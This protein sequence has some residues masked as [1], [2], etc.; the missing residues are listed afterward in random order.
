M[1]RISRD[2]KGGMVRMD[3]ID[4]IDSGED[5]IDSIDTYR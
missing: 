2:G 5:D 3:G 1:D 4:D